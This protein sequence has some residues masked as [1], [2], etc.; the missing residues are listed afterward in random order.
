M[1]SSLFKTAFLSFFFKF[2]P[3]ENTNELGLFEGDIILTPAQRFAVDMGLDL[4]GGFTRGSSAYSRRQWPNGVVPYTF[5]PTICKSF[6]HKG[7]S[8]SPR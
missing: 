5:D 8:L 4:N 3:T 7:P 2:V 6:F 1:I